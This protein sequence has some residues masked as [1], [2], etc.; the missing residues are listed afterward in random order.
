ML[1]NFIKRVAFEAFLTDRYVLDKAKETVRIAEKKGL[2]LKL[3]MMVGYDINGPMTLTSD[4]FLFP[5]AHVQRGVLALQHEKVRKSILSAW[6]YYTIKHFR[7]IHLG[8]PGMDIVAES[9]AMY[10]LDGEFEFVCPIDFEKMLEMKQRVYLDAAEQGLKLAWQ[11]NLSSRIACVYVEADGKNRGDLLNHFFVE[12]NSATTKMLFDAVKQNKSFGFENNR[13]LFEPSPENVAIMDNVLTKKYPLNSVRLETVNGK[14]A[15]WRDSSDRQDF[16]MEDLAEF[17][18][19]HVSK[20]WTAQLND[21]FC[22]DISYNCGPKVSK[23]IAAQEMAEKVFGSKEFILTN[24]GDKKGDIFYDRN[25]IFFPQCGTEA[26]DFCRE[27]G[28]P[29]VDVLHAGDYSLIIAAVKQI[30]E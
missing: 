5:L 17:S 14:I 19:Q 16:C 11:G 13:I 27:K 25:T 8:I 4:S 10:E 23:E 15:L 1:S 30:I 9:G 24:T 20:N 26:H 29:F 3:P 21:D 22:F 7:D 12:K 28:L 6:D 18:K 2:D